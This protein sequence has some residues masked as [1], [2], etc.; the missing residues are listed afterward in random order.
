MTVIVTMTEIVIV[1][2]TVMIKYLPSV[3]SVKSKKLIYYFNIYY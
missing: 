2:M 3:I 1:T